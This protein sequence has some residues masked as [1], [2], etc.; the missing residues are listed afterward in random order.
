MASQ[1]LT[2]RDVLATGAAVVAAGTASVASGEDGPAQQPGRAAG[3]AA[4]PFILGL[5]TSTLRGHKLSIVEEIAIA[6]KAGYGGMEPWIDELEKYAGSGGSLRDLGKRFRDAGISVES[7][8]GFFEWIVDDEGRR[9]KALEAARRSMDLVQQVGGRRLAAPPVGATD[10]AMP[11][12]IRVAGRYRALLELGDR[13]GVVPEVEVWGSSRTL[14]RLGEAAMVAI[15]ADHP[16]ACILP[17][18]YHLYRG[19]SGL[20]GVKLLSPRSIHVFHFNDYPANPP[21]ERLTDADRVYPGDGTA[22]LETLLRDLAEGGFRVMLSLE[23]FNRQYWSQDPV[24]VA[25]TGFEKM[26]AL[27]QGIRKA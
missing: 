13:I 9:K 18:V 23:L 7:A 25:R 6:E 2:R 3:G 10:R 21:R 24:T 15:E 16:S 12:L 27:V 14:G 1:Q 8:I 19:G 11:D 26:N 4:S 20:G 22:P 5:N 17:D